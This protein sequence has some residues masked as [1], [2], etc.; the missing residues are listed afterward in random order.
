MGGIWVLTDSMYEWVGQLSLHESLLAHQA[1]AYPGFR[2]VKRLGVFLL[3]LH[4]M[5]VF[6]MVSSAFNSPVPIFAVRI[7]KGT[8]REN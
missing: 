5:L 6:H 4:G 1:R 2:R 7:E 3:L 8:M